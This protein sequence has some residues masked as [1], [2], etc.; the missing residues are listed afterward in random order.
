MSVVENLRKVRAKL[1][2]GWTQGWF[3]RDVNGDI[4]WP[5][6]ENATCWCVYGACSVVTDAFAHENNVRDAIERALLGMTGSRLVDCWNDAP[7]RTQAEVLAL[8]DRAIELAS[9]E[10]P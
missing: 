4:T 3:A 5:R 8:V 6:A 9:K 1:E 10:T 7:G 2:Q